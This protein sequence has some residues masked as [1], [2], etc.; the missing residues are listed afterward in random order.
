MNELSGRILAMA[1]ASTVEV[2][3]AM[4]N[5]KGTVIRTSHE[6]GDIAVDGVGGCV[7][8]AGNLSGFVYLLM[9]ERLAERVTCAML[10]CKRVEQAEVKDVVGEL[11]NM[12]AGGLKNRLA[13][14]GFD[15]R[16]TIPTFMRGA[17]ARI[18]VQ[19]LSLAATNIVQVSGG[20]DA[21]EV[22]I[23]AR[24]MP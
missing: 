11:T 22:R 3:D 12:V 10:A 16:L 20:D 19:N 18:T 21:V 7:S 17:G 5:L 4:L 2:F 24:R 15:S 14:E 13:K 8:F 6:T 1:E 23:L 9:P